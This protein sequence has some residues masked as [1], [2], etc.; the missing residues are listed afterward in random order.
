MGRRIVSKRIVKAYWNC[1]QC[2][3]HH[4]DGLV[5]YC[6]G[7]GRHKNED[8][9]YDLDKNNIVEVS[10]DELDKAGIKMDSNGESH[11]DW[12][13]DYCDSLNNW[14]DTTC[15]S[16]GSPREKNSGDYFDNTVHE[17]TSCLKQLA[18]ELDMDLN[19][20]TNTKSYNEPIEKCVTYTEADVKS[21]ETLYN[22][23]HKPKLKFNINVL[24]YIAIALGIAALIG[25]AIWLFKPYDVNT[26][27]TGFSWTRNINIEEL[28]TYNESGWSLP[29]S[30]RLLYTKEELYD[31]VQEIDYYEEKEVTYTKKEIV[32]YEIEYEI[33]Y[34]DNGDGTYTEYT[35]EVETPI[36]DDVE[37]TEIQKVPVYKDVEIYKTK[38]YYEIDRWE[39]D[40]SSYSSG[41]NKEPYWNENFTLN[42]DERVSS[43][44]ENYTI[45]YSNGDVKDSNYNEWMQ[46][47][48]G[49]EVIITKCRLGIVYSQ[50]EN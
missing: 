8:T 45:H 1:K 22:R 20:V 27:V 14:A 31:V 46:T 21:M 29:S 30:A 16:C 42:S 39:H 33:E 43:R 44:T 50:K 19:D 4:I 6:P 9:Q 3:R 49:D 37:Y 35:I 34:E 15:S 5:D 28:N 23:M 41:S 12:K 47:E 32:D 26:E 10:K 25:L 7:C 38:Y 11:P 18:S 40:Y 2:G 13:C 48:L 24:K 36:Y 17:K